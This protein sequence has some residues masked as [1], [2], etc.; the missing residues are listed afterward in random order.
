M[1]YYVLS[2]IVSFYQGRCDC[3]SKLNHVQ[4]GSIMDAKRYTAFVSAV[5]TKSLSG[6]GKELGYTPSGIIRLINALEDELGFPLLIRSST[7]VEPTAEGR[8][9]LPIFQQMVK[10]NEKAQQTS[11]RIRGLAEGTLTVGALDSIAVRWLPQVI[12]EYQRRFPAVKVNV[13]EGSDTRLLRKLERHAVDICIFHGDHSKLDWV[14]L[15][16]QELVVWAPKD[17]PLLKH[18]S[19]LL[20]ELDGQPFI[21]IHPEDNDT[22]DRLFFQKG[23]EPDVRFTTGSCQTAYSMVSAGLGMTLYCNGIAETW[24]GNVEVRPLTPQ[25]FVEFGAAT[26]PAPETSPAVEEFLQVAKEF[27]GTWPK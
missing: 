2:L 23:L 27:A 19:L 25:R 12:S 14:P 1:R 16:T 15:G 20:A 7:G 5:E 13:V 6:A 8:R 21:R 17:S 11:A 18:Q 26:L 22:F 4:Q 9:M 10:L 3:L 24:Q